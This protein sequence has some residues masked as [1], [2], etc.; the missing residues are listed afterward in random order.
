[1]KKNWKKDVV[2]EAFFVVLFSLI[3]DD[4]NVI[5]H[6]QSYVIRNANQAMHITYLKYIRLL[7]TAMCLILTLLLFN[8]SPNW[9]Y[10]RNVYTLRRV[11]NYCK[12]TKK[13]TRRQ[14]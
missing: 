4:F 5:S 8:S 9:Q 3:I 1:M 12:Q 11:C 7:D 6:V 14:P 13:G 10:S 2:E